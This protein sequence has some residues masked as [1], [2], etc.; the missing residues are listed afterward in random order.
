MRHDIFYIFIYNI[1]ILTLFQYS[2]I[3]PKKRLMR[4]VLNCREIE[5]NVRIGSDRLPVENFFG[6]LGS[7][8]HVFS[9]KYRWSRE[10]FGLIVDFCLSLTI[11]HICLHL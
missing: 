7:L 11:Y 2:A 5:R 10:K 3:I 8:L 1:H 9:T 4:R 6:R